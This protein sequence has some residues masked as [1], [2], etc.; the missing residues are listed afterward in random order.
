M[1]T[2]VASEGSNEAEMVGDDGS[3]TAELG[4]LRGRRAWRRRLRASAADSF[5]SEVAWNEAEPPG[6][7]PELGAAQNGGALWRPELGYRRRHARKR[8]REEAAGK[9]GRGKREA[10][11]PYPLV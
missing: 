9:K 1:L 2:K 11:G 8:E 6:C 5:G 7:S 4:R 10:S 3:V